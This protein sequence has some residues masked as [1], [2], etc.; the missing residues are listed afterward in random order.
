[1]PSLIYSLS[2]FFSSS[3]SSFLC[4]SIHF[5]CFSDVALPDLLIYTRPTKSNIIYILHYSFIR[6]IAAYIYI[7]IY[8]KAYG[9]GPY[10]MAATTPYIGMS[11]YC[12]KRRS[13]FELPCTPDVVYIAQH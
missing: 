7:Y 8:R 4:I 2:I 10:F 9:E 1:M 12:D 6:P 3:S 13:K 11:I 5:D